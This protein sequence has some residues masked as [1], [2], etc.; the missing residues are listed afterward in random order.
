MGWRASQNGTIQD[1]LAQGENPVVVISPDRTNND[2]TEKSTKSYEALISIVIYILS[3][4]AFLHSFGTLDPP[5]AP[6][7]GVNVA[8]PS[9]VPIR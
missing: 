8:A 4:F 6:V 5:Q 9:L 2:Q 1:T 3:I 7:A